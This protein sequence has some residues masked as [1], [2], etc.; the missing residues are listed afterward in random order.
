LYLGL[1]GD[2]RRV[3]L[4]AR[5]GGGPPRRLRTYRSRAEAIVGRDRVDAWMRATN[6]D[7]TLAELRQAARR[8]A[9]ANE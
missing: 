7:P 6:A 5:A 8:R 2:E 3:R 9:V 1:V 4:V